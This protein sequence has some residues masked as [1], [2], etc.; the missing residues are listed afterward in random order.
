MMSGPGSYVH[1][2]STFIGRIAPSHSGHRMPIRVK[3]RK[4]TLSE[5]AGPVLQEPLKCPIGDR[6]HTH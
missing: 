5:L 3:K 2:K 6:S 1:K 4:K